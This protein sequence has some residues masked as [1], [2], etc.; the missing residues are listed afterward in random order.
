MSLLHR[1][2]FTDDPGGGG[3]FGKVSL[4]GREVEV[5]VNTWTD[6]IENAWANALRILQFIRDRGSEVEAVLSRDLA[7]WLKPEEFELV[8]AGFRTGRMSASLYDAGASSL[9]FEDSEAFGGHHLLEVQFD[10][11]GELHGAGFAG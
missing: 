1:S 2:S 10:Q 8:L 5:R 4:D 11:N 6:N 3:L 7:P 9:Y